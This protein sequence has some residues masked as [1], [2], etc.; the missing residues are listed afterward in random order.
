MCIHYVH[1]HQ[2]MHTSFIAGLVIR[3]CDNVFIRVWFLTVKYHVVVISGVRFPLLREGV[4]VLA[5]GGGVCWLVSDCVCNIWI[6]V[7]VIKYQVIYCMYSAYVYF[8]YKRGSARFMYKAVSY[9]PYKHVMRRL[10]NVSM[11]GQWV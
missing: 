2:Q 7:I 9:V 1:V 3:M 11:R 6:A 10:M 8:E 4:V 5:Y